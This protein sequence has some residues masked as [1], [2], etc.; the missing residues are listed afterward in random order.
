MNLIP[1]IILPKSTKWKR[2]RC[3][4][5]RSHYLGDKAYTCTTT[6]GERYLLCIDCGNQTYFKYEYK[7]TGIGITVWSL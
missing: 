2:L 7:Y 4:L 3:F 6:T 1:I 5:K